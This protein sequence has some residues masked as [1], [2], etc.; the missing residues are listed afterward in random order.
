VVLTILQTPGDLWRN[1]LQIH[2]VKI[3]AEPVVISL[4]EG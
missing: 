3:A 1:A 4:L 2:Q